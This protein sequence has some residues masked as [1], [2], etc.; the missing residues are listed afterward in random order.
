MNQAC[1]YRTVEKNDLLTPENDRIF[2]AIYKDYWYKIFRHSYV[3]TGSK[4]DAEDMA[5]EVFLKLWQQFDRLSGVLKN[6]EGYLFIMVRNSCHNHYKKEIR[7]KPHY[8]NYCRSVAD[9]YCH[10]EVVVNEISRIAVKAVQKLPAKQKKVFVYRDMGLGRKEIADIMKVSVN[11]IDTC[12]N[13]AMKKVQR[14]VSRELELP[15]A[16]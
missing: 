3:Y 14:Y 1:T 12:I 6:A 16:A 7:R 9:A 5:Q 2:S 15:T 13:I 10:D 11:T 8:K 4:Q